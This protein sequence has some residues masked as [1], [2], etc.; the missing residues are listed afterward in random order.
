MACHTGTID[1]TAGVF[2]IVVKPRNILY[3]NWRLALPHTCE[4][5]SIHLYGG[6][7]LYV[8]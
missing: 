3:I 7:H 1:T 6:M 8:L 5:G 2:V 4:F